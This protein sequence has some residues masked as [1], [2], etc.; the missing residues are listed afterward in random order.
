MPYVENGR[1]QELLEPES[2]GPECDETGI[3]LCH[4]TQAVVAEEVCKN[5]LT[6]DWLFDCN[7]LIDISETYDDCVTDYCMDSSNDTLV[8]ILEQYL[9]EC[10]PVLPTCHDILINWPI[11]A[12]L[13]EPECG[14]NQIWSPCVDVCWNTTRCFE[15]N[16]EECGEYKPEP[17][18]I[19]DSGFV[20]SNGDCI[21]ESDCPV[22]IVLE[23]TEWASCSVT[24]GTGNLTRTR[25][26]T[27]AGSCSEPLVEYSECVEPDCPKPVYWSEWSD[28]DDCTK[29]CGAG[30]R[31][32]SRMCTAGGR[33]FCDISN[34]I[35]W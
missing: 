28:F 11:H 27:G 30:T 22:G 14:D 25:I 21:L 4:P 12:N 26:C 8:N 9:D 10:R 6:A 16:F 15:E 35:S 31:S 29:S 33:E 23:W 24:C 34:V 17:D 13:P 20:M 5:L 1:P 32:R 18:C 19:C 7:E 2:W 3:V